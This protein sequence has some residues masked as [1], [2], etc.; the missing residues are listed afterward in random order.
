VAVT[1]YHQYCPIARGAEIFAERWTP[2][3]IRNLYL[4]CRT[5]TE[6]LDGAPGM[7]KTLLTERLRAMER[8]EIIER[9]QR[10]NARGFTYHLTPAGEELVD[11]CIALGNWGARWLEVAPEHLGPHVVLWNMT[12]LADLTNLPQPRLVVRFDLTDLSRQNRY[13]L[14]LERAHAEVC[15]TNPGHPEDVVVTTSSEWLAKWH[16]GWISL[17]AAQR[18]QVITVTGPPRLVRAVGSLGRSYFAGVTP[19]RQSVDT[20]IGDGQS[21]SQT[22]QKGLL[23][24]SA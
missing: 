10:P 15:V 6:I 9:H 11:V 1:S 20:P 2:L 17:P 16:M 14:L 5:F 3:I 8:Y 21:T 22:R 13:W 24:G 19:K 4:G 18:R 7:S 12:R 23:A